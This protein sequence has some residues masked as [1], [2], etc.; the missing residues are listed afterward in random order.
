[1]AVSAFAEKHPRRLSEAAGPP[2]IADP[3]FASAH[4]FR[5]AFSSDEMRFL[6]QKT[7]LKSLNTTKNGFRY[8]CLL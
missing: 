3:A 8:G 2:S 7:L 4:D 1:M 6:L 5:N